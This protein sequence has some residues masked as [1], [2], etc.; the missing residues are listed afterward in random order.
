[1][2]YRYQSQSFRYLILSWA[3]QWWEVNVGGEVMEEEVGERVGG[4]V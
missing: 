2:L 3:C 1:M 4:D